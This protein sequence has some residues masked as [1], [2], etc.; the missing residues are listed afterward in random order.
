MITNVTVNVKVVIPIT[1]PKEAVE[2]FVEKLAKDSIS[3]ELV[4]A[5]KNIDIKEI[6]AIAVGPI[7]R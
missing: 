6:A 2:S 3:D 5:E 1:H 4:F 7:K